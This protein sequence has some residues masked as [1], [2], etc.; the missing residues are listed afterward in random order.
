MHSLIL[1]TDNRAEVA[2]QLAG[3]RWIVACFCAAWCDTCAVYQAAFEGLAAR[4]PDK[5]F[6]WIDIEDQAD[7]AGELDIEN[8]PT[9]LIQHGDLVAFFGTMLPDPGVA[10]R[11]L[12]AQ[13]EHGLDALTAQARSSTERQGWQRNCNLRTLL[14]AANK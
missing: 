8:F 9:L 5:L 14:S 6:V 11:L 12:Q 10:H 7:V 4:H 1:K 2:S 3:E 13:I